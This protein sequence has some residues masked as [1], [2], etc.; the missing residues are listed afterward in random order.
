LRTNPSIALRT[1][2]ASTGPGCIVPG[3]GRNAEVAPHSAIAAAAAGLTAEQLATY[4]AQRAAEDER[5]RQDA[6]IRTRR[7]HEALRPLAGDA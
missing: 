2:T 4:D 3:H 1:P 6:A 5:T 7:D